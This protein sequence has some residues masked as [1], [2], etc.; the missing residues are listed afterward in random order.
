MLLVGLLYV[1]VRQQFNLLET[2]INELK[3]VI[4][5]LAMPEKERDEEVNEMKEVKVE[6]RSELI[7]VSDDESTDEED[8]SVEEEPELKIM[9]LAP[10]KMAHVM[11]MQTDSMQQEELMNLVQRIS[12]PMMREMVEMVETPILTEDVVEIETEPKVVTMDHPY[13]ALT[14]K[15]LREKVQ[16]QGGPSLKTKKQLIDYLEKNVS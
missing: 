13:E 11:M 2:H 1:Y 7:E 16:L 3:T 6:K 15:E 14:V 8:E 12:M 9:H 4:K 10:P 5:M